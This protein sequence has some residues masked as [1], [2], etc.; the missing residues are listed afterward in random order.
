M[1]QGK[2]NTRTEKKN[3]RGVEPAYFGNRRVINLGNKTPPL[4]FFGNLNP[5]TPAGEISLHGTITLWLFGSKFSG[6]GR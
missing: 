3:C 6:Q 4:N 2:S 1:Q 5:R